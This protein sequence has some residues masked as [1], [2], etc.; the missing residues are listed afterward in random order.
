MKEHR[1]TGLYIYQKHPAIVVP[2]HGRFCILVFSHIKVRR[3]RKE[4]Y[5]RQ[6]SCVMRGVKTFVLYLLLRSRA[7]LDFKC[8]T[9]DGILHYMSTKYGRA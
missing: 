8:P 1:R 4:T 7:M 5:E 6:R 2:F 3:T 9:S